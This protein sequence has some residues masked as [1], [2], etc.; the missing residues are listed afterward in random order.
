MVHRSQDGALE[1][2]LEVGGWG[3]LWRRVSQRA[4]NLRAAERRGLPRALAAKE[5]EEFRNLLEAP[6][7][8]ARADE[9]ITHLEE[10]VGW[11]CVFHTLR[12][13]LTH[14]D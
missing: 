12:T 10:V 7:V 9:M 8:V 14:L 6:A 4:D 1:N 2:F 3:A 5:V 13:N 11:C